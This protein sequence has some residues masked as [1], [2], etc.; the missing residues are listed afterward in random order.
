[1]ARQLIADSFPRVL[2][3]PRDGAPLEIGRTSYS[4]GNRGNTGVAHP[5]QPCCK[6]HRIRYTTG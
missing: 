5:G 2:T 6:H 1:M 3:D 4:P